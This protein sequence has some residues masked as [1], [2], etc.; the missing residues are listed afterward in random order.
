MSLNEGVVHL[1]RSAVV[2]KDI[3]RDMS[4]SKS[5]YMLPVFNENVSIPYRNGDEPEQIHLRERQRVR[6][7]TNK[8]FLIVIFKTNREIM[9]PDL[10]AIFS[11]T[12]VVTIEH[13]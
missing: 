7:Q 6:A 3:V 4:Q 5:R 2:K 9:F 12:Q 11:V 8:I 10:L 13:H 1:K